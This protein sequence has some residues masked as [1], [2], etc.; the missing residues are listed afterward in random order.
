[1]WSSNCGTC[2]HSKKMNDIPKLNST[3]P[4]PKTVPTPLQ[5][6]TVALGVFLVL[7]CKEHVSVSYEILA[8]STVDPS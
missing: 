2:L 6:F 5:M 3:D 1:M 8:G 7:I 4:S